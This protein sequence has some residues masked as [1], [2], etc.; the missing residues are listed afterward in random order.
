MTDPDPNM[1]EEYLDDNF[2]EDPT[3]GTKSA[4]KKKQPQSKKR[5]TKP[6]VSSDWS[7]DDIFKLITC[8][9]LVPMLWNAKDEKYRNKFERQSAWK[10]MSEVDF[11]GKFSD[12]ELLAKWS[13]IRIQ[14]R[15]YYSKYQKTK[16]GQ[17]TDE[18]VKWKFYEAIDF[19]GRAEQEQTAITVSNLVCVQN[20]ILI[21]CVH[22]IYLTCL[23]F[24]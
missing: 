10:H 18:P 5:Q 24:L 21:L 20:I 11:E 22:R 2:D 4:A 19:V 23:H 7:D 17:E 12:S 14:Y 15:S 8:V 6:K 9:E 16:S 13:N 1:D 3:Y